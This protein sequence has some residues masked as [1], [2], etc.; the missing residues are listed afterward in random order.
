MPKCTSLINSSAVKRL[1]LELAERRFHGKFTR[2]SRQTLGM[3]ENE[4]RHQCDRHV[5]QMPSKGKTL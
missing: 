1:L 4:M 3:M 2:V 5:R